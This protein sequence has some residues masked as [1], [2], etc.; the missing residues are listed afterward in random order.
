MKYKV[1]VL[2]DYRDRPKEHELSAAILVAN[3]FKTNISFLRPSRQRTP[4]LEIRGI[5]WELKSPKG[6]GK[7]TI[8][9]NL[10]GARSQSKNI[11]LDLRRIKMNQAKAMSRINEYFSN[12]NSKIEHLLVISKNGTI[13]E[14][15]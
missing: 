4:D 6:D 2:T 8:K 1:E 9:N 3:Y 14:K 11:I 15:F 13:L 7:N 12:H 10:H 5:A